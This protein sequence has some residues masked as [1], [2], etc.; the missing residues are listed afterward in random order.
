MISRAP[1][2]LKTSAT[3]RTTA[4]CVLI[5]GASRQGS[6]RLGFKRTDRPFAHDGDRSSSRRPASMI[7]SRLAWYDAALATKTCVRSDRSFHSLQSVPPRP[8]VAMPTEPGQEI[9]SIHVFSFRVFGGRAP[10]AGGLGGGLEEGLTI[11]PS[12]WSLDASSTSASPM[13]ASGLSMHRRQA[14]SQRRVGLGSDRLVS[15]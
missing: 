6:T 13:M 12:P 11:R 1:H 4:G 3:A 10:P 8:T 7:D 14:L 9:A 2:R 5:W 15:T